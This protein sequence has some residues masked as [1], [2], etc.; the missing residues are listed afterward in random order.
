ME[1]IRMKKFVVF[2]VLAIVII[3][4]CAAQSQNIERQ[5][6]GTWTD[7]KN[8]TWVFNANG[9]FTYGTS[10]GRFNGTQLAYSDGDRGAFVYNISMSSDGRTIILA[11]IGSSYGFILIKN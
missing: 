8:V 10:N 5:I 6:V 9:T 4:S 3:T 2:F 11:P 1:D 7:Q